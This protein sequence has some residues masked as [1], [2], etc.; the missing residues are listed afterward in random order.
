[1]LG[2][3]AVLHLGSTSPNSTCASLTWVDAS[4]WE[5]HKGPS[6]DKHPYRKMSAT[7]RPQRR[8]RMQLQGL[9]DVKGYKL[10]R[11]HGLLYGL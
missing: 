2:T 3:F 11:R 8:E 5:P 4:Y 9:F 1:M 6:C 10:G 7:L